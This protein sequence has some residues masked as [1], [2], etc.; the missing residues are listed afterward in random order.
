VL[1]SIFAHNAFGNFAPFFEI[2]LACFLDGVRERI[3]LLPYLF[4]VFVFNI[5]YTSLGFMDALVDI[6]FRR[7]ATWAKTERFREYRRA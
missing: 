3:F 1:F 5:I 6:L 4:F 7:R 2:G